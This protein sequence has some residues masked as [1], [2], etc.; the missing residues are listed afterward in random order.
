MINVVIDESD[1]ATSNNETISKYLSDDYEIN[2]Q[3][4][5]RIVHSQH[6]PT[7]VAIRDEGVLLLSFVDITTVSGCLNQCMMSSAGRVVIRAVMF[8]T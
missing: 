7:I 6:L 1:T 2:T 5:H 8:L 4:R 3:I